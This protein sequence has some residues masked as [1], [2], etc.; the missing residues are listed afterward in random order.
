[1]RTGRGMFIAT[2]AAGL[3]LGGTATILADEK[4]G[5]ETV[6]CS[7]VNACKGQG[8]CGTAEHSCAGLNACKGKGWVEMSAE[9]C[10]KK[11]GKV[12]AP[13]KKGS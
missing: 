1:M 7:G 8:A 2:A 5:G 12:A 4:A 3:I 9:E 6:H 10:Q 11:G 13:A